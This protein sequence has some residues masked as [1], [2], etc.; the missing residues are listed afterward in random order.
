ME[1]HLLASIFIV[2]G[3][4]VVSAFFSGSETAMTAS[5]RARMNSLAKAGDHRATLVDRLLMQQ[6]RLIGG[7]LIG[8]NVVNTGAAALS[9]G[10]LLHLFG[11]AGI[12]YATVIVSVLVIIFC[13]I[14][15]KTIAINQPDQVALIVA[16]PLSIAV[17]ALGPLIIVIEAFVRRLLTAIGI[18]GMGIRDILSGVDELRGQ[19]DL[20]HKE[21]EVEKAERDMLEGLL[22]LSELSVEDVMVHRTKMRMIDADLPS[23][24]IIQEALSLPY[25][26]IPL[27]RGTVENIV[28][29]LHARDLLKALHAAGGRSEKIQIDRMIS[30]PW[31]VPN[32]T[33]AKAQLRAFLARKAHFALVIDE[34]GDVQGLVTLEDILE[35]IVGDIKDE[36]DEVVTQRL[37][38]Q[39]D[40]S[41]TVEGIMAIRDLNRAVEWNLPDD[42]ATTIAGL[43]MHETQTIPSEGQSFVFHGARFHVLRKLRNRITLVRITPVR[44]DDEA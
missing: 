8:N 32:V 15:P 34:Y 10:V 38:R 25:T 37:K 41:V 19:V 14:L 26:R 4:F 9:T 39:A 7:I 31:F 30:P 42:N 20:L 21:G 5:S 29:V 40:G 3:C 16:R 18:S 28:G 44:G 27:W 43:L 22:D 13:E 17:R 1:T 24:Q 36:H 23:D 33:A 6:E 35:E 12:L 2:L 11:D